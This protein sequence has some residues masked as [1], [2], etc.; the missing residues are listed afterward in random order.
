MAIE[1]TIP[2]LGWSMDE[3]VFGEWLKNDGEYIEA[4]EPIFLLESDKALQ[5]VESVDSGILSVQ[6]NGPNAG[7]TVRVGTVIG[8]LLEE[9]ETPPEPEN[10]TSVD[11]GRETTIGDRTTTADH[12]DSGSPVSSE[13]P[14]LESPV[15][16]SPSVRRLARELGVPLASLNLDGTISE[17]DVRR[18]AEA[19]NRVR[20][21]PRQALV[22][23]QPFLSVSD[24]PLRR[25]ADPALPKISPRAARTARRLNIDWTTLSGSG[26]NGRIRE[27]DVV[28]AS[29]GHRLPSG[30]ISPASPVRRLTAERMVRSSQSTAPVTLTTTVAVDALFRDRAQRK[31]DATEQDVVPAVH[32]YLV[33]AVAET[34]SENPALNSCWL[35]GEILQPDGIHIGIATDTEKGLIV[36][37]VHHACE[38]SLEQIAEASSN[39]ILRAREGRLTTGECTGGTF[40][41]SNLG[42]FGIDAFTPIVNHRQSAI[43]GAGAARMTPIPSDDGSLRW[44][45][46]MTLSL[47]FDHQ[48]TDGAPAAKFLQQLCSAIENSC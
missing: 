1:I 47:T 40:T 16:A 14:G 33:L 10:E 24:S 45:H 25:N 30:T 23:P 36:P 18:A 46:Q 3:G 20:T 8:W 21:R 31:R 38:K 6:E 13:L 41:I 42:S 5:E 43:L 27:H 44:S 9:G 34:L 12:R 2:R 22:K 4:G 37:V 19:D 35:N 39:L 32:D 29:G 11:V 7:D 26:Q 28:A 17:H 48:I 15:F